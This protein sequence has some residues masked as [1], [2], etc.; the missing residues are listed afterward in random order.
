MVTKARTLGSAVSVG[1]VIERDGAIVSYDTV[2]DLPLSGNTVGDTAYVSGFSRVYMWTGAGWFSIALINQN[3][4]FDSG[5][6]PE[7]SYELD[8]A[9]GDPLVIQ[10]SASDPEG[11]PIQW[12]Y[13]A[14]D[15]AQYF[16]DITNDSSVFT[17][18]AKDTGVI[19]Q[20]DS[21]GGT[22]SITFKASD[23]VNLATALSEFSITFS[24]VGDW[25]LA[26]QQTKIQ[27]SDAEAGDAFGQSV[28]ISSDGNTAIVG[29]YLAAPDGASYVFIRSGSVWSEQAII[30]SSDTGSGGDWF[31]YSVSVSADGNTAI[32]GA[33]RESTIATDSGAAYIFTRS[34]STWTEQAKIQASDIEASDRFGYTVSISGDGNTAIVGAIYEDTGAADAGASYIFVAG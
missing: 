26:S 16:A 34:G 14:S 28:S 32:I 2:E 9:G 25:T 3:P 21:A 1:G 7:V 8:S 20:Y 13:T 22:F 18:T 17:I 23:G 12:S 5:G 6:T 4:A 33:P 19:E 31:G 30:V 24:T 29:A 15:S 11:L 27:A 10:L